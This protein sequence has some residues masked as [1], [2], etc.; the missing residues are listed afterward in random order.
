MP[1]HFSPSASFPNGLHQALLVEL[2]PFPNAG[3]DA[4][5]RDRLISSRIS[6]DTDVGVPFDNVVAEFGYAENGDLSQNEFYCTSRKE[7]CVKGSQPGLEFGFLTQNVPGLFCH[8]SCEMTLPLIPERMLYYRI[9]YRLGNT[10]ALTGPKRIIGDTARSSLEK[11][12]PAAPSGLRLDVARTFSS[13][14]WDPNRESN[15]LGYYVYE[16]AAAQGPYRLLN[17]TPLAETRYDDNVITV[18]S[19]E[20]Y[21]VSAV[22]S[23]GIE[24]ALSDPVGTHGGA[25]SLRFNP[26]ASMRVYPNPYRRDKHKGTIVFDKIV[27]GTRLKIFT[28]S[29]HLVKEWVSHSTQSEWNLK[30]SVDQLAASGVYLFLAQD[31]AG[32]KATGKFALIK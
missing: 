2:P 27:A 11:Q 28:T 19:A 10:L 30:N 25:P 14:R 13:L 17:I 18:G 20:W 9:H 29:G 6:I 12:A 31:E 7:A 15:L 26:L 24:S 23:D 22:N 8:S 16:S 5:R 4:L 1:V 32:N 21:K 3:A